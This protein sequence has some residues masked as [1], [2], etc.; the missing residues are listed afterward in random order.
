MPPAPPAPTTP[1]APA[2]P[3]TP[4]APPAPAA[5]GTDLRTAFESGARAFDER[6]QALGRE[7]EGAARRWS[8]SPAVKETA[9]L[10]GRLWGL[11]LLALG[12][13]FL[14]DVTLDM[15]LPN[16]RWNELWPVILI[17]IGGFVV[18]RGMARRR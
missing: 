17:L 2:A 15:A 11:V 4:P 10:A 14:A 6:A 18:L 13:W 1:P 16:V 9:D 3:T 7:A 12:L 5:A 8:E